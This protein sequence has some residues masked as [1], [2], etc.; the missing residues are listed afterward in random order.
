MIIKRSKRC[1]SCGRYIDYF[2]NE[3]THPYGLVLECECGVR[4]TCISYEEGIAK[5]L[6]QLMKKEDNNE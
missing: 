5:W 3:D 2:T 6:E 4:Y 1:K